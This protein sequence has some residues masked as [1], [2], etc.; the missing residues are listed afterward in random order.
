[1]WYIIYI[2]CKRG[3]SGSDGK[4]EESTSIHC[5]KAQ[6]QNYLNLVTSTLFWSSTTTSWSEVRYNPSCM[7]LRP[8]LDSKIMKLW[9]SLLENWL[10]W[11]RKKR[12]KHLSVWLWWQKE[13][14]L[15]WKM[16]LKIAGKTHRERR[17]GLPLTVVIRR[18]QFIAFWICFRGW[19]ITMFLKNS[20]QCLFRPFGHC[21]TMNMSTFM[22]LKTCRFCQN[23]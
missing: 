6:E 20:L 2:C 11:L 14:I 22:R 1:M 7:K 5:F 15:W 9:I 8:I 21:S 4:L 10:E 17:N 18:I 16:W 13:W 12:C 3:E 19:T 23:C